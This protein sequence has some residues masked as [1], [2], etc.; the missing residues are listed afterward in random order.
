MSDQAQFKFVGET[1]GQGRTKISWTDE[2]CAII[3][4]LKVKQGVGAK[5]AFETGRAVYNEKVEAGEIEGALLPELPASYTNKN[6]GSVLYGMKERFLK[7]INKGNLETRAAAERHGLIEPTVA[8][9]VE[10]A[11]A[12]E[13]DI[14]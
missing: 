12:D 10:E 6:A 9:A 13:L 1:S 2:A 7:R 3:L 8:V 14:G 5:D 4:E 11:E